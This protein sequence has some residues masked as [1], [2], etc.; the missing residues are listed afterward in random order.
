MM[1]YIIGG[2]MNIGK[3]PGS[4]VRLFIAGLFLVGLIIYF[5]PT[6]KKFPY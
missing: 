2:I 6:I 5:T 1:E 3:C 4:I